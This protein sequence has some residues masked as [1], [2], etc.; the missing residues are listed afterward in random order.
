MDYQK[1]SHLLLPFLGKCCI[2]FGIQDITEVSLF[3]REWGQWGE[4]SLL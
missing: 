4:E 2:H 1:I 3:G